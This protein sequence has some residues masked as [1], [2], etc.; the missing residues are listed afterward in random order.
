MRTYSLTERP[1]NLEGETDQM[2]FLTEPFIV[3]ADVG[4]LLIAPHAVPD[5][6]GGY[7]IVYP[8]DGGKPFPLVAKKE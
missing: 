3:E 2:A 8:R 7:W 5:W 4:T 6:H 1:E